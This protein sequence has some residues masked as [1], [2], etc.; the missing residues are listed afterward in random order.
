MKG[1][2]MRLAESFRDPGGFMYTQDGI[3]LRQ[4]NVSYRHEYDVLMEGLYDS[5]LKKKWIVSHREENVFLAF[6]PE[7]AYKVIKPEIV[8]YISYP[9]EW[10][11]EQYKAAS[12]LMLDICLEALNFSMILKDA[13][14]YNIQFWGTRPVLIDTLSFGK[15]IEGRPWV[16]YGQF[17][18]HFLGPILLMS[19]VNTQLSQL[20]RVYIDGIPIE[21]TADLLPGRYKFAPSIYAHIFLHA[22]ML[23]KTKTIYRQ[24]TISEKQKTDSVGKKALTA[25][26]QNL[27]S[28][29][30]KCEV[31]KS[32]TEWGEY[33]EGM[34]NY[35]DVAFNHK[36]SIVKN[37]LAE[38][39]A[40][41]ICDM[42]GNKGEFSKVA[43]ELGNPYVVC[44]DLDHTAVN[45]HFFRLKNNGIK[46][47]LPLV[48][49]LTNPSP[50]MGWANEERKTVH[51]RGNW[52]CTMV[53]GLIH[54]LAISNNL[55]LRK[56]AGYFSKL[57]PWLIVE[58]VPKEDEQVQKLLF[59]KEDIFLEYNIE[60]FERQFSFFYY[61][62]KKIEVEDSVRTIYFMRSNRFST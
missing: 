30:S 34:M 38:C 60:E 13:S 41:S 40:K 2:N 46:N 21:L 50:A 37:F 53:L 25:I 56:I 29:I 8:P 18:K 36:A 26:L 27:K 16:A 55:P 6:A 59:L 19:K 48:L 17:C 47:I 5:L 58:F 11:F 32:I 52:D 14:A 31:K 54:H 57:S 3:L 61:I 15:Y 35:S 10:C 51:E 23:R 45:S 12:L 1:N 24:N 22:K 42:G 44:Y 39:S 9:F 62:E 20:M 49:D 4:I 7:S 33:Y 43:S 28:I